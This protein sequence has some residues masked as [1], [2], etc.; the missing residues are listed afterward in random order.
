M[1]SRS[2]TVFVAAAA[3]SVLMLQGCAAGYG[4]RDYNARQAGVEQEVRMAIV[5][6][7]REIRIQ[8]RG[9]GVG[10]AIGATVGGVIGS[11][12]TY[13]SSRHYHGSAGFVG[14]IA[15]AILGSVIGASIEKSAN[16]R[17]GLE[18]TVKY[19]G[20]AVKAIVQEADEKFQVGDRVRVLSAGGL[21]R[22]TRAGA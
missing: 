14:A 2:F 22:V 11:N 6:G 15:G 9:N 21:S 7:V 3:A 12:A 1:N 20:G 4:S 13:H 10:P 16:E 5:E 19:D 18:I 17:D 8:G